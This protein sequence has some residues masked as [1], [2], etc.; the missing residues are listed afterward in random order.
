MHT[1][2]IGN[3]EDSVVDSMRRSVAQSGSERL[4]LDEMDMLADILK[5]VAEA[6]KN[7]AEAMYYETVTEAMGTSGYM[8]EYMG[9]G[10]QGGGGGGQGG[11]GR[12]GYRDSMGRFASR[13]RRGYEGGGYG[14]S[15]YGG[16]YGYDGDPTQAMREAM[17]SATP[18]EREKMKRELRQIIGM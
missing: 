5:D 1:Q 7:C 18:E 16:G 11:G 14:G 15:G 10:G 13:P 3:I 6:K 17:G 4:D 9:Y 8:P 12:S 2:D